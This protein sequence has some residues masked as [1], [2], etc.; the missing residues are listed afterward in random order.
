[1]IRLPCT[2]RID[3]MLLLKAF[4]QGADGVIISGCHPGDCHYT[5]GNFHARRRWIIFR[6]FLDFLGID[7]RRIHFA[8]ISAAEGAKFA[9]FV[10][11][12]TEEIKKLG[13]YEP[14]KKAVGAGIE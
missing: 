9:E 7:T 1:M 4:D 11:G 12:V 2:G 5:S 6:E 8:W 3:F 14:Y 13:P 10:N